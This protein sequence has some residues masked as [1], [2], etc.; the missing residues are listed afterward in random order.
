M[1]RVQYSTAGKGPA[2]FKVPSDLLAIAL[3][4]QVGAARQHGPVEGRSGAPTV[5]QRLIASLR[6]GAKQGPARS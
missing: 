2:A 3:L 4:Q 5:L 6:E 1:A